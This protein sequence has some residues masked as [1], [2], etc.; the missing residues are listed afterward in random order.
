LK[1]SGFVSVYECQCIGRSVHFERTV[2]KTISDIRGG[3]NE[4]RIQIASAN[5]EQLQLLGRGA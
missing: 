4:G 2:A 1:R 3:V 5:G